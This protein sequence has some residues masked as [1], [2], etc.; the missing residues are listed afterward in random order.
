MLCQT[1]YTWR[2]KSYSSDNF[3]KDMSEEEA[4]DED[5]EAALPLAS[6]LEWQR[7]FSEEDIV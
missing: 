3:L 4:P 2:V 5:I 7:A 1:M 6:S